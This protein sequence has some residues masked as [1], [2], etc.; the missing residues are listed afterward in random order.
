MK[1]NIL[2]VDDDADVLLSIKN[3]FEHE[4]YTVFTASNGYD[5]IEKITKGFQGI[6]LIDIMMP[7]MDGWD[8]IKQLVNRGLTENIEIVVMTAIGTE[9]HKKMKGLEPYIYDYISKPFNIQKLLGSI[10]KAQ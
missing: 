5:C 1:K 2:V 3:I 6:I 9:N 4:G 8:T 7:Q 10:K